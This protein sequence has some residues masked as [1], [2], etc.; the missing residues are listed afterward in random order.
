[1]INQMSVVAVG[2]KSVE[3]DECNGTGKIEKQIDE[4]I[5]L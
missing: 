4:I 3:C 1:M 2:F 5:E